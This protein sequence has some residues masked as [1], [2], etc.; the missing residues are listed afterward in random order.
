MFP[1]ARSLAG[2]LHTLRGADFE[3]GSRPGPPCQSVPTAADLPLGRPLQPQISPACPHALSLR[4]L[5]G[6]MAAILP[7]F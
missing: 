6:R 5:Q 2:P 4:A 7:T 1:N 3:G